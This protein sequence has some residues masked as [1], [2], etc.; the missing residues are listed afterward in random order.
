MFRAEAD[1]RKLERRVAIALAWLSLHEAERPA[2]EQR[3]EVATDERMLDLVTRLAQVGE[4]TTADVAAAEVQLASTRVR[5]EEDSATS[6]NRLGVGIEVRREDFGSV[7]A[8]ANLGVPVPLFDLGLRPRAARRAEAQRLEG[9]TEDERTR[10]RT[11]LELALHEVEHTAELR[12][13]LASRLRPAA[14]RAL[15]RRT[16]QLE[17]GHA[18][19]LDVLDVRR[20]AILARLELTSAEHDEVRARLRL[21]LMLASLKATQ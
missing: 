11:A 21:S 9:E 5:A 12:E 7:V 15:A 6:A 14:E 18:T 13:V 3:D 16:R 2:V 17:L 1:A 19:L 20:L 8:L 4:R 10:A